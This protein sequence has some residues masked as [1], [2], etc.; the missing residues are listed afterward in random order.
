MNKTS[1]ISLTK[2]AQLP[3]A[4]PS[5]GFSTTRFINEAF[6]KKQLNPKI[7]IEIN[8]IPTLLDLVKTGKW[9]TILAQTSVENENDLMSIP[10]NENKM[11]RTAM[12]IQ[13]ND[14]YEKKSVRQFCNYL[15]ERSQNLD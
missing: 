14:I 10:I 9:N 7:K 13:L 6:H 2:I 4:L 15:K 12:I 8:D 3:L 11:L 5:N 1:S